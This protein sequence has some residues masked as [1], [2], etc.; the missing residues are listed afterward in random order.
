MKIK[1]LY[2]ITL[3]LLAIVSCGKTGVLAQGTTASETPPVGY[4]DPAP[5]DP[6]SQV[7]TID[8]NANASTVATLIGANSGTSS[9]SNYSYAA[10]SAQGTSSNSSKTVNSCVATQGTT[11]IECVQFTTTQTTAGCKATAGSLGDSTGVSITA[12]SSCPSGSKAH[13]TLKDSTGVSVGTY[14]GYDSTATSICALLN[15]M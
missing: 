6:S 10:S 12:A 9:N 1:A 14:Y 11:T 5:R 3:A 7:S 4:V 15:S 8:P 2:L 13:C